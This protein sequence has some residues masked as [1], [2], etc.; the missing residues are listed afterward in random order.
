MSDRDLRL[1]GVMR[2]CV[3]T[4]EDYTG[5]EKIG[6]VLPCKWCKQSL[7]IASDGVWEWNRTSREVPRIER[8]KSV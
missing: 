8:D 5:P 2:C 1:G 4:M 6:T 7:I 3:Q